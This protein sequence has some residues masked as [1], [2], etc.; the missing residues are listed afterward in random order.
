MGDFRHRT[1]RDLVVVLITPQ[2][3]GSGGGTQQVLLRMIPR[4]IAEGR[5]VSLMTHPVDAR[6]S[7][8]SEMIEIE[9]LPRPAPDAMHSVPALLS[10]VS[11]ALRSLLIIRRHVRSHPDA[12]ALAFLPGSAIVTLIATIG[13]PNPVIPCERNDPGR[14]RFS[15]LVRGLRKLLYRRAAAITVN[16]PA[17]V[18]AFRTMLA[19]RIPVHIVANPLPEWSGTA[20]HLEREQLIVAVGRLVPQKRHDD[21]IRAFAALVDERSGWRL[22]LIGDGPERERLETLVR[23]LGVA[24]AVQFHGFVPHVASHLQRA[25]VFV[26]ASEY[27]GTPNALLEALH[28]GVTC[29]TSD[30]VHPLPWPLRADPAV[31]VFP[32]GDVAALSDV[33]RHTL[34]DTLARPGQRLH[35]I[36][37]YERSVPK[38]WGAVLR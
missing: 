37:D 33:L 27:E 30:A 21:T 16:S 10:S 9:A 36:E 29:I 19:D 15:L 26:L 25:R 22:D 7:A 18:Q 28:S 4:W 2:G 11:S 38:S 3:A 17:A 8:I 5:R 32:V 14:Q 1:P 23:D 24:E 31:A 6:W 20:Q 35:G 13:L 34:G 12:V